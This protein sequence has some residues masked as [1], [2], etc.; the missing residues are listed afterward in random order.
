M[1]GDVGAEMCRVFGLPEGIANLPP[2]LQ[3]NR[4]VSSCGRRRC[5]LKRNN[6]WQFFRQ[7]T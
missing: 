6:D 5:P 3:I 4:N 7:E 1:L 2:P